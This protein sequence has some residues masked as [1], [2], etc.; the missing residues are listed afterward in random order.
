MRSPSPASATPLLA[1]GLT[2]LTAS[3]TGCSKFGKSQALE[4]RTNSIVRTNLVQGVTAN[5][6]MT[7]TRLVQVGSQVSGTITE[8]N[9]DFNSLVKEGEV[10][11][12]I[13]PASFE[14]ALARADAD[15]TAT[16]A[17][18]SLADFNLKRAKELF[19]AKL[20]SE[21][22]YT[23]TDVAYQQ[24]TANV[25]MRD[26]AVESARVDLQRTTIYAPIHGMVIQR[27][28]EV[29]QTVASSFNTPTLF[30]IANDLAQMQIELA[31]SEADIGLIEKGQRVD[32]T[33]EAYQNRKFKG[34][35]NQVR[36]APTT[37]QNVV[38]YTT[39]VA[40]DNADMRL[41]P[42][43]TAT[44]S[45]VTSERTNILALS[46]AALR[47]TPPSAGIKVLPAA[48]SAT[49]T[50]GAAAGSAAP[51]GPDGFPVPPWT[52]ESRRPTDDER[53]KF[54]ASL[55]PEQKAAYD[56]FREQMRARMAA[57]GGPGG[58]GGMG[59]GRGEGRPPRAEGPTTRTVYVLDTEPGTN[60]PKP[61][62]RPVTVRLGITD[63]NIYEVL[64]GLNE[65]DVVVTGVKSGAVPEP[66]AA[67]RS[68][69][70]PGS[71]FG[72]GGGG[73]GPR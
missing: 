46:G 69:L 50:P 13:D 39:V 72:G 65:G 43:M 49:P 19:A 32:F 18:L 15:L 51:N 26:A 61:A 55:N 11:A 59:G 37:N 12:K 70:N 16:K 62:L 20:I 54:L 40:V 35:V 36:F 7:P 24:A 4:F 2:L 17:Q 6:Q 14:R 34:R 3:L 21:T 56:K 71:P 58:P 31:V 5:G 60:P 47:F 23:Q 73:R 10:I 67:M 33:V 45:I 52:A 25:R 53:E 44:A 48:G 8:L 64:G 27:N 29:G 42:G 57:G 68:P 30:T 63:N 38:T 28:I 22:E 1:V 41:R 9:V 66:A